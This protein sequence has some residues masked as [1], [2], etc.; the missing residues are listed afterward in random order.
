MI[1]SISKAGITL[2]PYCAKCKME[3]K[4]ISHGRNTEWVCE[5]CGEKVELG[6]K[7]NLDRVQTSTSGNIVSYFDDLDRPAPEYEEELE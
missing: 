7:V 5:I 2:N 1:M 4:A 3:L 6:V